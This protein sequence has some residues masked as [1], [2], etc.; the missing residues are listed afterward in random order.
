MDALTVFREQA[1]NR[2]AHE[3][4]EFMNEHK[5]AFNPGDEKNGQGLMFLWAL[6]QIQESQDGG[7]TPRESATK[8]DDE[9]M[10][11]DPQITVV[12]GDYHGPG[13]GAVCR[14]YRK[15]L[16]GRKEDVMYLPD[17]MTSQDNILRQNYILKQ[18]NSAVLTKKRSHDSIRTCIVE[19]EDR[20]GDSQRQKKK[21]RLELPPQSRHLFVRAEV[22]SSE[23]E[24]EKVNTPT[25]LGRMGSEACRGLA[26][27][28]RHKR[29]ERR[30]ELQWMERQNYLVEI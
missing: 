14:P 3:L 30:H 18:I 2:K 6:H 24:E 22:I 20:S 1:R 11:F 27:L 8:I 12:G 4:A 23:S 17:E 19:V 28:V 10:W 7:I 21:F 26:P 16:N 9:K 13:S 29:G 5:S 25:P 15:G